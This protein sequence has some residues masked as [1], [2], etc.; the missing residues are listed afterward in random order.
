MTTATRW[1]SAALGL[2][3]CAV[4]LAGCGE[5]AVEREIVR[6]V[7]SMVVEAGDAFQERWFP[8]RAQATQEINLAFEVPG[9][10]VERP[11]N[12]GD[13]VEQG[14]V[15][16]RLDP[17]DYENELK[18]ARAVRNRSRATYS[19]RAQAAKTGA[20]SRQEVDDAR[21]TFEASQARVEIAE[22]ALEDT[23]IRAKFAGTVATTY[24]ENFQ[25]VQAKQPI[26]RVLD[27]SRIEMW[28]DIPESLISFVPYVRDARVRFDAFPGRE[29]PAEITEVGNEASLTT[30]TYPV[31]LIMEQP[32]GVTILPG[33]AG[34]ASGRVEVPGEAATR[35][36]EIPLSA[37]GTDD[38]ESSFVWVIDEATSTVGKRPVEVVRV[39]PRGVLVEGLEVGE[40]IATAGAGTLVEGQEVR[41][42][43]AAEKSAG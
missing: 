12:V 8:G 43:V 7:R 32:D 5:E 25:N 30:R 13:T 20:V 36:V 1:P 18:A 9:Q 31:K 33:M 16:A 23:V 34:E 38:N 15:L 17:R 3:A 19:R 6:P 35:G 2:L 39:T 42:L 21:A 41:V 11:V 37:L 14:R 24:V 22:K 40:R 26:L 28:I 29:M 27:T 10:L 4:L